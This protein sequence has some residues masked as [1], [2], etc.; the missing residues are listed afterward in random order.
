MGSYSIKQPSKSV[1]KKFTAN[2]IENILLESERHIWWAFDFIWNY[3]CMSAATFSSWVFPSY[4]LVQTCRKCFLGL[5]C[6]FHVCWHWFFSNG[7]PWTECV[8]NLRPPEPEPLDGLQLWRPS[9]AFLHPD[10]LSRGPLKLWSRFVLKMQ[11]ARGTWAF[12]SPVSQ[13]LA[14]DQLGQVCDSPD[15]WLLQKPSL[16]RLSV[17]SD[18][19]W[20]F[21]WSHPRVCVLPLSCPAPPTFLTVSTGINFLIITYTRTSC[22]GLPLGAPT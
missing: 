12:A 6:C 5:S 13:P 20:G 10:S 7:A 19:S 16:R 21:P 4:S 3:R 2:G 1:K 17:R 22:R 18:W 8:V 15:P 11:R 9:P 14:N